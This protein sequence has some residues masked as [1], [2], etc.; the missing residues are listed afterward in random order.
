MT[1]EQINQAHFLLKRRRA[2]VQASKQC[3]DSDYKYTLTSEYKTAGC[4]VVVPLDMVEVQTL[5][6][7]IIDDI[8]QQ[9]FSLGVSTQEPA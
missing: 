7:F 2:L 3:S 5:T 1:P 9:L 4:F 8:D 6:Q